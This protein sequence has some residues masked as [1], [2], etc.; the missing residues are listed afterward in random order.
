MKFF[1][2]TNHKKKPLTF[3]LYTQDLPGSEKSMAE[4][5]GGE[6]SSAA[7]LT[8]LLAEISQVHQVHLKYKCS[9]AAICNRFRESSVGGAE[10]QENV[11]ALVRKAE[12]ELHHGLSEVFIFDLPC[13]SPLQEAGDGLQGRITMAPDGRAV[14]EFRCL[15]CAPD[16]AVPAGMPRES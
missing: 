1:M 4:A 10:R 6:R 9:T 7:L 2:S 11:D 15:A 5:V 8:E 3:V 14:A 12:I 16:A 13:I